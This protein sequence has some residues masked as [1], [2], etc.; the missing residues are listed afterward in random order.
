MVSGSADDVLDEGDSVSGPL[1][2][3]DVGSIYEHHHL[4]MHKMALRFFGEE[5][6]KDAEDAVMAVVL[7]LVVM[8]D[9][10]TLR[11]QGAYWEAY[12]V[13]AVRNACL[14]IT[15]KARSQMSTDETWY[16]S[17][18]RGADLDPVGDDVVDAAELAW[19]VVWMQQ[20]LTTMPDRHRK[21]L[22][23]KFWNGWTNEQ[24]GRQLGI[25]GQA[26]SQQYKTALNRLQK[27][28]EHD[29]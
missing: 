10:G 25:T 16:G 29:G 21:I 19:R 2:R 7:R 8:K 24:I 26:V 4:A 6:R 17:T 27:E 11:D 1:T 28:V 5:R 20:A 23:R 15:R 22:Q 13:K 18:R 14:D 3:L 9:K 12:L